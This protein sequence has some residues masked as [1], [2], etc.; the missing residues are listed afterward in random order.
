VMVRQAR[1][2]SLLNRELDL[3]VCDERVALA[4][5]P[6]V[7]N[8][9]HRL[10]RLEARMTPLDAPRVLQIRFVSSDGSVPDGPRFML[11]DTPKGARR[12]SVNTPVSLPE[13]GKTS[14]AFKSY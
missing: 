3:V 14:T 7:R 2:K 11:G 12:F 9:A 6:V 13:S 10:K 8:L 5:S 1:R 4:G